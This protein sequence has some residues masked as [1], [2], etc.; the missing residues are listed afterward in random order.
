MII[1]RAFQFPL[2]LH[3]ILYSVGGIWT[4][5]GGRGRVD[6]LGLNVRLELVQ[7]IIIPAPPLGF[8]TVIHAPP[9]ALIN[10]RQQQA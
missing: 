5:A 10:L 1:F 2:C 7:N 6:L 9:H 8:L 4:R 3:L